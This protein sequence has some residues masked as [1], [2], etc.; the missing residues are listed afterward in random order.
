MRGRGAALLLGCVLLALAVLASLGLGARPVPVD[1]VL[2]SYLAFDGS[3]D[4]IVVRELRLPRT[5][6]GLLVGAALGV[7]G[8]LMQGLSRN[9]VAD[10]GLLGVSAGAALGVVVA[11]TVFGASTAAAYVWIGVLGAAIASVVV[12]AVAGRSA[13]S[14]ITALVLAGAAVSATLGSLT[15]SVLAVDQQTLDQYRFWAVGSLQGRELAVAADVA[16]LV[17]TGLVL[18]M[19]GSRGLDALALGEDVAR[20]L[21]RNV[22][23]VRIGVLVAIVLLTGGAVAA[24]GPI[25]FV[26]LVVPHLVR[27]FAGPWHSWQLML[28]AVYAPVLVLVA[29]V[30]GRLVVRPAELPVGIVTAVVGAPFLVWVVRR[31]RG[32]RAVGV[33]DVT[34]VAS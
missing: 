18:A 33:R 11:I 25:A 13:R 16:P 19:L 26:G 17:V 1:E 22:G 34:T 21:G 7:A 29:D 28:S 9:P 4:Q 30:V 15:A 23:L 31:E 27:P 6:V 10:P 8:V 32:A 5:V 12:F 2:G 3:A 20:A 24:A 14:P